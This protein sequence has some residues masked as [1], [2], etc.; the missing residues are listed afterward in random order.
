[1]TKEEAIEKM[2]Q[3]NSLTHPLFTDEESVSSNPSG[4]VLIF[5]DGCQCVPEQFWKYRTDKYWE[6]DWEIKSNF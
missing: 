4:T 6:T 5:E 1:M 3:G 2:K